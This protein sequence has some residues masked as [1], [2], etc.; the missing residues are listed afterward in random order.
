MK[1]VNLTPHT[2]VITGHGSVE[3]SGYIARVNT[4]MV[5]HGDVNGIPIVIARNLGVSNL[6]EPKPDT[7]Y[8]V[9]GLVRMFVPD[10]KDVCSPAKLIRN[11]HGA[12]VGCSALE[13]NP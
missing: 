8:I 2:I 6:P 13:V 3:P 5:Q 7:M 4:Q 1:I 9:A 11:E 10:R 12:V